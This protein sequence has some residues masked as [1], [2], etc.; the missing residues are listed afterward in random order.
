MQNNETFV[1]FVCYLREFISTKRR[2][3]A[4]KGMKNPQETPYRLVDLANNTSK[5]YSRFIQASN[6]QS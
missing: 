4:M 1:V 6:I 5:G 2:S 3:D